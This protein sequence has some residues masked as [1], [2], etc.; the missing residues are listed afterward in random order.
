LFACSVM[1]RLATSATDNYVHNG[2]AN[3]G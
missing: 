2:S 3:Q 1:S